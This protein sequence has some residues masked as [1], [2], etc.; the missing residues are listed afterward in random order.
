MQ[1][2]PPRPVR[3]AGNRVRSWRYA[4][5]VLLQLPHP[6]RQRLALGVQARFGGQQQLAALEAA[7]A[8]EVG[9]AAVEAR[10]HMPAQ[11][12]AGRD[13]VAVHRPVHVG[14][15]RDAVARVVVAGFGEGVEVRGLDHRVGKRVELG[16]E[17]PVGDV[18]GDIAVALTSGVRSTRAS[19]P[20]SCR[21]AQRCRLT[22]SASTAEAWCPHTLLI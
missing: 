13:Q 16:V 5:S 10:A 12:G 7:E 1:S 22:S 8:L 3:R 11:V 18:L 2:P 15:E 4:R 17:T 6:P 21:W 9:D 19:R 14:G 20:G